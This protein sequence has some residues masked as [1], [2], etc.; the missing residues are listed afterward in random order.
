MLIYINVV[1]QHKFASELKIIFLL[2]NPAKADL[3]LIMYRE[4]VNYG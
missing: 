1:F 4:S 3:M 2:L